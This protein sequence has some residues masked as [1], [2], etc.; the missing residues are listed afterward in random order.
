[1]KLLIPDDCLPEARYLLGISGGRDS[2]ALLEAL[3][4]RG[5]R[6]LVLCHLNHQLRGEASDGD[7]RLVEE[8]GRDSDLEVEIGVDAVAER[9]VR[10]R[11]S[12][13]LAA[14]RA[15][16]AFFLECAQRHGTDRLFLAHHAG[17]QVETILIHLLR[18]TGLR[19]LAGMRPVA[20]I[21]GLRVIRPLLETPREE[22]PC[23][24]R[25]REDASNQSDAFL[26]NRLRRHAIPVLREQFG[27]EFGPALRRMAEVLREE[28]LF[29]NEMAVEAFASAQDEAG[30]LRLTELRRLPLALQRRVILQWLRAA[31]VPGA[32]FREVET[33][34]AVYREPSSPAKAN[35]PG[36][37]HV[38]RRAGRVFL[39]P[40]AAG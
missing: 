20:R 24:V 38:R 13:E 12:L 9:A 17:D 21:G 23:P 33:V 35:L 22:I 28:D 2:V 8:L 39:E 6:N 25:F 16:I 34:G 7:A 30:A 40:P 18:G 29:L 10:E 15:R 1:V 36:G 27:R 19:G 4:A 26:R 5:F 11:I 14:R 31:A 32:G 3:L 37:W